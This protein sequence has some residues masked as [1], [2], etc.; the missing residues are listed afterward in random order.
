MSEWN[1]HNIRDIA[2]LGRENFIDGDWIETPFITDEGIRLIQTGNIGI[3]SFINKNK[4]YISEESFNLLRCKEVL[5]GDV[6]ICR[7]AEPVGRACIVPDLNERN[8]TSVD[9]VIFRIDEDRFS[10][11]F[12]VQKINTQEFL[13]KCLE[14][15]AGTTRTRISRTNLGKLELKA[16]GLR[17]QQKIA[18]ILTTV[19]NLIEKTEALIEKYQAIKQGMMHDLFTRGIDANGQLR[20]SHHV[21]PHIYKQ[22]EL[23]WIPKEW[24]VIRVTEFASDE[25]NA[26]VDGPF[27]SNLKTIHYRETGV[28]VIQSGF[29]TSNI[30]V[31]DEY[32]YVDETKFY[33]EI[34]SKVGPGDIVMAKIGAQCGR[35]AIMPD[36]HPIGIL[37]GNSLKITVAKQNSNKYLESL[38][39]FFQRIG[40]L[41][42]IT[43]TTAQPAI[44]MSSLKVM[45]M[46]YAKPDEQV[47][48]VRALSSIE[49]RIGIEN[50]SLLKLKETKKGL[51]QDLLTGA[52]RVK[53]T[54]Q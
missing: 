39:H 37:A 3:G 22:T 10:K 33:S 28:P 43:S 49:Q 21:A 31:A 50:K 30:F 32:I 40:K 24:E 8:I 51:M 15:S 14:V 9:V 18:K 6:L 35:C 27:G 53:S 17:Q 13:D 34:R 46:Q 7:L 11:E 4:K 20:P 5:P 42:L 36:N 41:D 44:S 47:R 26:I 12:V 16:P 19:D 45:K 2:K 54:G 38:L 52:V 23:G 1:T 25:K 29:V 48:I